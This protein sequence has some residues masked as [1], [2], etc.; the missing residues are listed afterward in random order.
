MGKERIVK[1]VKLSGQKFSLI[2]RCFSADTT[3]T[4]CTKIVKINPKTSDRYYQYFRQLILKDQERERREFLSEEDTEVDE[5]YFGPM[6]VRGRRGRGAAKKIAV[7][8]LLER[9]GKVFTKPVDRCTKKELL[10]VILAKVKEGVDVFTDGWKSYDGLAVYGFNHKKVKH[11]KNEFSAGDGNHI[12]G[13]ESFWSFSK[14]RL[15]QFNGVPEKHFSAYLKETEW[16]FNKRDKIEKEL[17]WLIR[18]DRRRK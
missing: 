3:A 17:R 4:A 15:S 13:I 9:E 16:R 2:V 11:E 1:R 14:R 10:P 6:R 8:G 5:A 12:N 18:K 7:V